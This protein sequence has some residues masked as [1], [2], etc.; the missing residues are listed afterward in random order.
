MGLRRLALM[1]AAAV[2]AGSGLTAAE[3]VT[4]ARLR[5]EWAVNPVGIDARQPHLSWALDSA[6]RGTLQSAYQLLVASSEATLGQDRG[7]LWDSGPTSS[8]Q[9]VQI[10][11]GGQ[12]LR[13]GQRVYWKVR[14]WDEGGQASPYSEGA[15]WEMG[16]LEPEDWKA[17]WVAFPPH[18]EPYPAALS[19]RDVQWIA[20]PEDTEVEPAGDGVGLFR[21][22]L[23]LPVGRTLRS[24]R[25]LIAAER[26]FSLRV[27]GNWI[28]AGRAM[29]LVDLG[30]DL[31]PG[32]NEI[33]LASPSAGGL[34]ARIVVELESGE[35]LVLSTDGSWQTAK[36]SA[37]EH[38]AGSFAPASWTGARTLG[39]FEEGLWRGRRFRQ[40]RLLAK[41]PM[42]PAPHLRKSFRV[43]RPLRSARL[44]ATA[45]GVY[46]VRLNGRRVGDDVLA[47]GWTDYTKRVQYQT[48]DVTPF[49]QM[50]ANALGVIVG[51]GWYAGHIGWEGE[52]AHYGAETMARVQLQLEYADGSS[53][54]V[55]SDASWKG[56]LGPILY[57]DFLKGEAYDARRELD[58]WDTG[59]FSDAAWTSVLEPHA[60]E[61]RLV[62]QQGP[63]VQR[64]E[65]LHAQSIT[66]PRPGRFVFDLGQNMVGWARL[67]V[68]GP[69]GTRVQLRF[70]EM[71]NPDG[72]L[73]TINLRAARST[74]GYV[75]KGARAAELYEPRF[76]F[77][78]FRY[79][80]VRGYPGRPALDAVTGIVVHSLIPA[81]GSLESSSALVNRLYR[82]IDWGQRGNFVSIP[83]D[84]PQRDER[85]GW[86]GDAQIFARTAC[87]N[88]DV[89]GFFTKWTLDLEDA[90]SVEGGFPN[91]APRLV[92]TEDGAPAWADAGVIVP[93]TMYECYGDVPL[94][95]RHYDAMV[96]W[97]RYVDVA[98]PDHLWRQR[99]N[100]NY[101][102]WVAV[103]SATPR[104]LVA[105]AYFANSA[106][107]T[108]RT[109]Q[110][111]GKTDDARRYE[112]LFQ[113]IKAAFNRE[114]VTPSGRV[115][116]NTQTG[117]ALALR[118]DLLPEDKRAAAARY[119]VEDVERNGGLTTGFLGVRHLLPALSEAGRDDV[120]YRLLLSES[121]PSWGYS[122]N[123]G[124]TTIWE[125]WDGWTQ[126]KGFQDTGMNSFNHYSFG[127]VGEWMYRYLAG[128]ERDPEAPGHKRLLLRPRP[129][130]GLSFARAA[131]ES[132]YGRVATE[133][134]IDGGRFT[135]NVTVP[136]NTTATVYV[137]GVADPSRVREG[138]VP[139]SQAPGVRLLRSE[140]TSAV[141]AVGSGRYA[142][143]VEEF[144]P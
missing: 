127:S 61:V 114:F 59:R 106:R 144:R 25:L 117:Y 102:D 51:D 29:T 134:R 6:R 109:A 142:F 82:N 3:P 28:G 123:H 2:F 43:A 55:A 116:G 130:G 20:H 139:A 16:L 18:V 76:T 110:V 92:S 38:R 100:N 111:L 10:P 72:T 79:V 90:Q 22:V 8:D 140:G 53:E 33:G 56:A 48:Y 57:S 49:V 73:Y 83:T 126:E 89:A 11:Y 78:G 52:R 9:A 15:W 13:S 35:P 42:G 12:A 107:L 119:L 31:V 47:P 32:A 97:V 91:V 45:L 19:L 4:V 112:E 54:T 121:F 36:Q 133:W 39:R 27:N 86:T 103:N 24:A 7:D 44:Y 113:A 68:R 141:Y 98:N 95:A 125:R 93:W 14:V 40:E 115:T 122:I 104:D 30:D 88:R 101:G 99:V 1:S 34:A 41:P 124:A 131:Y 129:G 71:L 63:P 128:I 105:T 21:R 135:L 137:P 60:P 26:G 132:V 118:F 81:T 143:S 96:R 23:E 5:C 67:K 85:L 74:D 84:C 75:L 62:A 50:G 94:L 66:E 17:R 108:A 120:A 77:H 70:S 37:A 87:L 80:E 136:A 69:A 64:T 138:G 46:E 58:G 65:E